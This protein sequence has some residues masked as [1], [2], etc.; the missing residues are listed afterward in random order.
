MSGYSRTHYSSLQNFLLRTSE[1]ALVA[2]HIQWF[3]GYGCVLILHN[4]IVQRHDSLSVTVLGLDSHEHV[5]HS[6]Q[7]Q[8][9]SSSIANNFAEIH[10]GEIV[11][12]S[13][14]DF[15]S[16]FLKLFLEASNRK[17]DK[18]TAPAGGKQGH[19]KTPAFIHAL[20]VQALKC[21][22]L[23]ECSCEKVPPRGGFTDVGQ[24]TGGLARDTAF[25]LVRSLCMWTMNR[26][27][28]QDREVLYK[29]ASPDAL[30]LYFHSFVL[31][32]FIQVIKGSNEC[33]SSHSDL[34]RMSHVWVIMKVICAIAAPLSDEGHDLS[35]HFTNMKL[36]KEII[37]AAQKKWH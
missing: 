12:S 17:G 4:E 6:G 30:M 15:L 34:K 8:Y 35:A 24:H 14:Q 19:Q 18:R 3:P 7:S 10:V 21:H 1:G 23:D 16:R 20:L 11:L 36:S 26:L 37:M 31:D 28:H 9:Q 5:V 22:C 32:D 13:K 29:E 27:F 33:E 2:S 25:A